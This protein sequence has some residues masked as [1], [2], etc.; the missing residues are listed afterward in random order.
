MSTEENVE[1][2]FFLITCFVKLI[3]LWKY[4]AE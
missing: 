1:T 4:Q 2:L 3:K